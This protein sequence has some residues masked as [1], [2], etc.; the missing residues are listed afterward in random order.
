MAGGQYDEIR[1]VMQHLP[2]QRCEPVAGIGHAATINHLARPGW[3]AGRQFHLQPFG[4]CGLSLVRMAIHGG[5]AKTERTEAVAGFDGRKLL[6]QEERFPGMCRVINVALPDEERQA[7]V[8]PGQAVGAVLRTPQAQQPQAG[9]GQEEGQDPQRD[10]RNPERPGAPSSA[11]SATTRD[12]IPVV[13]EY[14]KVI[15]SPCGLYLP[16]VTQ[17]FNLL[18]RRFS[19]C[20]PAPFGPVRIRQTCCRTQIGDTID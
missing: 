19:T 13:H 20:W 16:G 18:Y 15:G 17:I 3:V 1:L 12:C 7:L 14:T 5:A 9:F 11:T 10:G 2:H 4:K 6:R 8:K